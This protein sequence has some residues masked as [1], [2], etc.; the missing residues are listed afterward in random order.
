VREEG[1]NPP[2]FDPDIGGENGGNTTFSMAKSVPKIF[3]KIHEK[4]RKFS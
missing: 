1:E 4:Q 2:L 3:E